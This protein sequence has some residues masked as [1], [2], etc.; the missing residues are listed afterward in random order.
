MGIYRRKPLLM[1]PALKIQSG[2]PPPKQPEAPP[3]RSASSLRRQA[4]RKRRR[5][6]RIRRLSLLAGGVLVAV[7]GLHLGL[8]SSWVRQRLQAKVETVLSERLGEV[9]VGSGTGVD[10]LLH[11]TFGPVRIAPGAG[12]GVVLEVERVRV[13]PQWTALLV[14]RL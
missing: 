12:Q 9:Q 10:W 4:R 13:R 8:N 7:G 14:G 1:R 6:R 2:T 5:E 11:V 3:Q